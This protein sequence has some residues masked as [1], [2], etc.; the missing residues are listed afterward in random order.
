MNIPLLYLHR[1]LRL[2]PALAAGMLFYGTIF[3]YLSSG[4]LW[5][6]TSPHKNCEVSWWTTLLYVQNYVAP[7]KPVR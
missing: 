6:I 3:H 5:E 4:P 2:T 7:M 1:Y